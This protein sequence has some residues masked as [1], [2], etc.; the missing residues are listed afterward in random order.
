MSLSPPSFVSKKREYFADNQLI[1]GNPRYYSMKYLKTLT[2]Y[3]SLLFLSF[4]PAHAESVSQKQAKTLAQQFFNEARKEVTPPVKFVYNGKNLTVD[5]LFTPFYVYNSPTGGF[6]IISAENKTF[7][8]LGYSFEGQFDQA[9]LTDAQKGLL[10]SFAQSIEYVR[11][12]VDTPVEAIK[13]W[14]DYP[15]FVRRI[16]TARTISGSPIL[17]TETISTQLTD[18]INAINETSSDIYS[19]SQWLDMIDTQLTLSGEVVLGFPYKGEYQPTAVT[20]EK[21]GYY[22]FYFNGDQSWMMRILPTEL[23]TSPQV[24]VIGNPIDLPETV[25]EEQPFEFLDSFAAET[26]ALEAEKERTLQERLLPSEPTIEA[27]TGGIFVINS[28][29]DVVMARVYNLSGATIKTF[30]YRDTPTA[31]IDISEEPSGFYVVM[32]IA[33]DGEPFGFKIY[34]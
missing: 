29:K 31:Y 12:E 14:G 10:A 2:I 11:F 9:D 17:T 27:L 20:A 33:A 4:I 15:A 18:A 32:L 26:A 23:I 30:K 34:R 6:V 13:A 22:R 21:G 19:P 24:A 28:P 1:Y 16:L 5:R 3:I 7:P 25:V 8:I